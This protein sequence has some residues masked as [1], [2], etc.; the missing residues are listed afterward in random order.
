M[1][2]DSF[3]AATGAYG[4]DLFDQ[5]FFIMALHQTVGAIP[6]SA[7][8]YLLSLQL[9]DGGWEFGEGF[10]SDSNTTALVIQTMVVAGVE[11]DDAAVT[12]ALGYF[13][14]IQDAS[15]AFGFLAD[16]EPDA[17]STAFVIQALIAVGED[18][19]AGGSWATG[20]VTPLEALLTFQ[21]PETGAFQFADEDSPFATYQVVPGL[22][23][24]PFPGLKPIL[25]PGTA[26]PVA[27]PTMAVESVETPEPVSS[28]NELPS[29]GT[30]A[31]SGGSLWL[32]TALMAGGLAAIGTG[33]FVRDSGSARRRRIARH[34]RRC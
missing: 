24:A 10:G 31:G 32:V 18:I 27:S 34:E 13:Q 15:G 25:L 12:A 2:D 26:T 20:G 8:E 1:V 7:V 19:D 6:G 3:D 22:V 17:Q 21:N 29:T 14:S 11:R 4:V 33:A 16:T 28:P 23:L 30:R 9:D 5:A